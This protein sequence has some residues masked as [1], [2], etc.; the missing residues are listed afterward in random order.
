MSLP[1]PPLPPLPHPPSPVKDDF[2]LTGALFGELVLESVRS[3]A[4][5][6][7]LALIGLVLERNGWLGKDAKKFLGNLSMNV[8]IPC[9]LFSQAVTSIELDLLAFAWPMFIFPF[10]Y[11]SLGA[12]LGSLVNRF[13]QP[14]ETMRP[15]VLA[16]CAFGNST[17][18][19]IV[20]VTIIGNASIP[21]DVRARLGSSVE[22]LSYLALYLVFY[23]VLQWAAGG[24]LL[25]LRG[26]RQA[27][28]APPPP[29]LPLAHPTELAAPA[30]ESGDEY[31]PL[32]EDEH[33]MEPSSLWSRLAALPPLRAAAYVRAQAGPVIQQ[34]I[35][36]PVMGA[37]T[38]CMIGI[39]PQRKQ[40]LDS[41]GSLLTWFI[42]VTS[43]LGGAAVP[44]NLLLLG[45][46]LSNGPATIRKSGSARTLGYI[47]VA[48]LIIMPLI[49]TGICIAIKPLLPRPPEPE[50]DTAFWLVALIV[51]AT[52]TANNVLVIVEVAGGD[53]EAMS[54][55]IA[56]QYLCAPV[57][58]TVTVTL[59]LT[60][61]RTG[62]L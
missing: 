11:V 15:A 54:A 48:K 31:T 58:L 55:M 35:V 36:P 60:V 43:L 53:T 9:L 42:G 22:P 7:S 44:V 41:T 38:G 33:Y 24:Y 3:I 10:I 46:S 18:L 37:M 27:A 4:T 28:A 16:A 34:L 2:H 13:S 29:A 26:N 17:G 1:P 23:P 50:F 19:P 8:T 25:G 51:S 59:F 61:V 45:S 12:T 5:I 14:K 39:L 56:A 57:L 32:G 21:A 20:L 30:G 49:A 47:V 62:L 40:M 52:P 6:A